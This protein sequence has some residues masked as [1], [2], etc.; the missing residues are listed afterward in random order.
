MRITFDPVK[1]EM[2]LARR[3][4]DFAR[5]GEVFDGVNVTMRDTRFNYG[6]AREITVGYLD[7]QVVV[8][9]WTLRGSARRIISM[10]RANEREIK[11]YA[12]DLG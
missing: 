9:V 7:E 12:N 3:G 8:L 1:R 6:E 2:T 5:A 11:K 4:L 10:R